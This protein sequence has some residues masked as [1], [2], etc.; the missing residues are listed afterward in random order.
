MAIKICDLSRFDAEIKAQFDQE[1]ANMEKISHY[2]VVGQIQ[3]VKTSNK[4]YYAFA[5]ELAEGNIT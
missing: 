2:N 3:R 4:V 5:M 1:V